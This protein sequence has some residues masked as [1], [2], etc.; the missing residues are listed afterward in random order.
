MQ[1][2]FEQ[3]VKEGKD[4]LQL[5]KAYDNERFPDAGTPAYI[6]QIEWLSKYKKYCFYDALKYGNEPDPSDDHFTTKHPG[7]ITNQAL[8]HQE[9]KYLR[10]T[11]TLAG[12]ETNVID[13]YLSKDVRERQDFEFVNEEIWEFLNSRYGCDQVIKRFYASRGTSTFS[14]SLA[15]IDARLKKIPCF[16]VNADDLLNGRI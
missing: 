12:F 14:S 15:E 3:L 2:Q 13:T 16:I 10:G 6:I 8:L 4:F 7:Q 9:A 5:K 1:E 11:G